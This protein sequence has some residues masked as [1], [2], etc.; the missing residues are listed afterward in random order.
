MSATYLQQENR[1]DQRSCKSQK[2]CRNNKLKH[3]MWVH[4]VLP[5]GLLTL[6]GD[7]LYSVF[8]T[9]SSPTRLQNSWKVRSGKSRRFFSVILLWPTIHTDASIVN[10]NILLLTGEEVPIK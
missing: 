7:R 8:S 2:T 9:L 5:A 10:T 3:N 6:P 4:S 1:R